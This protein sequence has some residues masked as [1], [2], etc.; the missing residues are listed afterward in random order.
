MKSWLL[1]CYSILL[2]STSQLHAQVGEIFSPN[3]APD[4]HRIPKSSPDGSS[5]SKPGVTKAYDLSDLQQL[6]L[7][8]EVIRLNV[9]ER[10]LTFAALKS[11]MMAEAKRHG[12]IRELDSQ[13]FESARYLD[14]LH[15]LVVKT[16]ESDHEK[17]DRLLA[18]LRKEL[19]SQILVK[20]QYSVA[21]I[22]S[23]D[24]LGLKF[25]DLHFLKSP[26][27]REM[28]HRLPEMDLFASSPPTLMAYVILDE[29][30]TKAFQ[31]LKESDLPVSQFKV[32]S[33]PA[34]TV[35]CGQTGVFDAGHP[36]VP[37]PVPPL[38]VE[39]AGGPDFKAVP[40]QNESVAVW[41]TPAWRA[42]SEEID[43][44]VR[45]ELRYLVRTPI[46]VK[47]KA[48]TPAEMAGTDLRE[49]KEQFSMEVPF[50]K[51]QSILFIN[52]QARA[53]VDVEGGPLRNDLILITPSLAAP[54]LPDE[55]ASIQSL[56]PIDTVSAI[57]NQ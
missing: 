49:H 29:A 5:T 16:T 34:I 26:P 42:D 39:T 23:L 12:S 17:I 4:P 6:L 56:R 9:P 20:L 51:G 25:S 52:F 55:A 28:K 54:A 13:I 8:Q 11:Y 30:T 22:A 7:A 41:L 35:R 2:L 27:Q 19:Q 18:L 15:T 10:Q 50:S 21:P 31:E 14:D 32:I 36:G 48:N 44:F 38:G 57:A 24:Q 3:S 46:W 37:A 43:L 53:E 1:A 40:R 47:G 45:C 33:E